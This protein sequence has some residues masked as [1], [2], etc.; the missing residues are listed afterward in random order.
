MSNYW[1]NYRE[2][3]QSVAGSNANNSQQKSNR[4]GNSD[5]AFL[6]SLVDKSVKINRGGPNSIQGKLLAVKSDYLVVSTNTGVV[7]VA[8]GH[9]KSITEFSNNNKSGA[10]N[11]RET[12]IVQA[13]SFNGVIRAL[14]HT[15][16]QINSG[17]P[18]KVEGF[19]AQTNNNSIVLVANHEAMQI[20]ND[21][22]Q[23]IQALNKQRSGGN[24]NKNDNKNDNKS[25]NKN[26]NKSS[27]KNSNKSSSQ[28]NKT[29][30][31]RSGGKGNANAAA[32]V[33]AATKTSRRS[34]K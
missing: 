29:Q 2:A 21:H 9:V 23:S 8:K 24:N 32:A 30:G 7:Y 27:N 6:D 34:V 1:N 19:L 12:N 4:N 11:N 5:D 25:S 3:G 20:Q 16:V 26:S 10:S 14:N 22:I 31:N 17:G 18:E 28:N 13:R 15:F 33:K